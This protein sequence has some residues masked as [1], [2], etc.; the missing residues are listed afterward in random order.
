MAD[1]KEL[2]T[3][4]SLNVEPGSGI[5]NQLK[6]DLEKSVIVKSHILDVFD[7]PMIEELFRNFDF[8]VFD[9]YDRIRP[10]VANEIEDML[11]YE[12][13]GR[14]IKVSRNI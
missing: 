11:G 10:E 12:D 14:M 1:F 3:D 9:E 6:N 8:L 5:I 4:L 7:L 2:K 13:R